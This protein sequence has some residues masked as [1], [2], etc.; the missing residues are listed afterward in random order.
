MIIATFISGLR[1]LKRMQLMAY[2]TIST[3][4]LEIMQVK[5]AMVNVFINHCGNWFTLSEPGFRMAA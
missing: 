1:A 3:N 5:I 4:M 2:A